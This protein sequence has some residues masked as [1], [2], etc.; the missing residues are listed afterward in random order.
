MFPY[1]SIWG[2]KASKRVNLFI[3]TAAWGKILT[4]DNL[5][6]RGC[7]MVDW[8]CM[9]CGSGSGEAVDHLLLHCPKAAG[10]WHFVFRS[11]GVQWVLSAHVMD[12]LFSWRNW[13]EKHSSLVW[14]LVPMCFMWT[15]WRERNCQIF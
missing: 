8:C 11:F 15:I 7:I 14:N 13:L 1:K 6:R 3:W 12:L 10:L 4:N 2:A 9:C 5:M